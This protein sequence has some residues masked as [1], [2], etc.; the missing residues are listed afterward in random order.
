MWSDTLY[1]I[2]ASIEFWG[3]KKRLVIWNSNL[4]RHPVFHLAILW[5]LCERTQDRTWVGPGRRK[6]NQGTIHRS[7]LHH[8]LQ[9]LLKPQDPEPLTLEEDLDPRSWADETTLC[10]DSG[11]LYIRA[12]REGYEGLGRWLSGWYIKAAA[13]EIMAQG[14]PG[15]I[16]SHSQ[17]ISPS[18][19]P[20]W[21]F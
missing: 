16:P 1:S 14:N 8:C 9:P 17:N 15:Q 2:N 7:P 4:T 11:E 12:L 5:N 13:Q 21:D 20:G 19:Q 6:Q 10:L 18:P 3:E